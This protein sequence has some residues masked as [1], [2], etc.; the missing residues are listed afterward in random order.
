MEALMKNRKISIYLLL[1]GDRPD[2]LYRLDVVLAA[3]AIHHIL[4]CEFGAQPR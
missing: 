4:H 1:G 2:S 3:I